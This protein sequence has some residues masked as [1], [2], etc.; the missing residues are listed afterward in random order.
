M[1]EKQTLTGKVE[2]SSR[3]GSA[4]PGWTPELGTRIASI[5]AE[6]GS[7]KAAADLVGTKAE[8]LS[9]WR[10]G[11]ARM[12]LGA[13]I[14][15]CQATR[16]SLDWLANGSESPAPVVKPT[17][18]RQIEDVVRAVGLELLGQGVELPPDDFARLVAAV[19][20]LAAQSKSNDHRGIVG[21]AL[22]LVAS[23]K[24]TKD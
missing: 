8:Q 19:L 21:P 9:K 5:I 20:E 4:V 10:D 14:T 17:D 24:S 2:S 11:R 15:L 7:I 23:N 3:D 12:P 13:A 16:R 18:Y 1:S 22:R 6:I